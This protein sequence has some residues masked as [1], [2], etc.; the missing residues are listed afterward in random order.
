[1][2]IEMK[3]FFS[4][5]HKKAEQNPTNRLMI[6]SIARWK[7]IHKVFPFSIG[8]AS[9][10]WPFPRGTHKFIGLVVTFAFVAAKE[11]NISYGKLIVLEIINHPLVDT[12]NQFS[13]VLLLPSEWR[14]DIA[15][16]R[17]PVGNSFAWIFNAFYENFVFLHLTLHDFTSLNDHK[18]LPITSTIPEPSRVKL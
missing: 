11:E 6:H 5:K 18:V 13:S 15:D 9:V 3:Q 7:E 17:S 8:I 4:E 10:Y 14:G 12:F 2:Q 1:M 16:I